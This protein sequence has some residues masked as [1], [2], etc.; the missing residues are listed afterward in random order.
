METTTLPKE[1]YLK[2]SEAVFMLLAYYGHHN[3]MTLPRLKFSSVKLYVAC[4]VVPD[5]VLGRS[6]FIVRQAINYVRALD[7]NSC[8]KYE[9]FDDIAKL[10][11]L[12]EFIWYMKN[13][14]SL[15]QAIAQPLDDNI[16]KSLIC[17][18]H[19]FLMVF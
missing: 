9:P 1:D 6:P 17:S 16:V 11:A 13:F 19:A 3:I 10:F 15:F 5:Y 8:R 12:N 7:S 18:Q 2:L 4:T 14:I